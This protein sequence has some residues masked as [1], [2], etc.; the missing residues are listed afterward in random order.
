MFFLTRL[1]LFL[2]ILFSFK[3]QCQAS[4]ANSQLV[5]L[6]E[7][8]NKKI[9]EKLTPE[10]LKNYQE[11]IKLYNENLKIVVEQFWK[12]GT[13]PRFVDKLEFNKIIAD[14][15]ANTLLLS[16][17]KYSFN[18]VDYSAYKMSNKLYSNRDVVVENYNKKQLPYRAT[19]LEIKKAEIPFESNSLATASMPSLKQ[20]FSA[21]IYALKSLCLQIDYRI[22]GTTEVQL[23]KMYIKNAP[24]LKELTL[25]IDQ[26]NIDETIKDEIKNHYKLPFQIVHKEVIDDAILKGDK[27]KAICLVFPNSDG[28]F[29][30]KVYDAASMEIL[31]QTATIPPSEYYPE[32]NNKIK[33]NHFEDFTHYCD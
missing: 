12:I 17:S 5:V 22:K 1:L 21:L 27:S 25:L 4:L 28:S 15:T 11:E 10:E 6:I 33:L 31:G 26:N 7:E 13:K 8:T 32:L 24:H 2:S 3:A 20:D 9:E 18:Y 16:N 30:F 14:K 19:I 23:M 29:A